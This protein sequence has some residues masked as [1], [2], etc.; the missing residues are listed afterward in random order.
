MTSIFLRD[1]LLKIGQFWRCNSNYEKH[2]RFVYLMKWETSWNFMGKEWEDKRWIMILE[3][4]SHELDQ[5][6]G[7][8]GNQLSNSYTTTGPSSETCARIKSSQAYMCIPRILKKTIQFQNAPCIF[9]LI[10]DN[11]YCLVPRFIFLFP[12][13]FLSQMNTQSDSSSVIS[14]QLR[15]NICSFVHA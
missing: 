15:L 14:T 10:F 8:Q 11:I 7:G 1:V 4:T 3:K 6:E 12:F 2:N 5:G 13:S 9:H